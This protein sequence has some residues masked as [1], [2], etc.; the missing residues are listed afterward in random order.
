[1]KTVNKI[2]EQAENECKC[3]WL[4]AE[5]INSQLAEIRHAFD[6]QH[7]LSADQIAKL[8]VLESTLLNKRCGWQV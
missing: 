2:I 1:M 4:S 7:D 3:I 6:R 8:K 5:R